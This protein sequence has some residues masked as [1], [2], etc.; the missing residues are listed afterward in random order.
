MEYKIGKVFKYRNVKL[1]CVE[2]YPNSNHCNDCYFY[3]WTKLCCK[4]KCMSYQ[5]KDKTDVKFIQVKE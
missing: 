4:Q 3:Q 1:K 5:R 2:Y